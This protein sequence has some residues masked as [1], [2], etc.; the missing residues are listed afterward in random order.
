MI[1]GVKRTAGAFGRVKQHSGSS[2]V[3]ISFI[4]NSEEG[5]SSAKN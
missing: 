4:E 3:Y 1:D 5:D 2:Q